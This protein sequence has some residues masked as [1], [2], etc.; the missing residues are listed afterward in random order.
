MLTAAAAVL[1]VLSFLAGGAMAVL[2]VVLAVVGVLAWQVAAASRPR[3]SHPRGEEPRPSHPCKEEPR[4]A[5]PGAEEEPPSPRPR[6]GAGASAGTGVGPGLIGHQRDRE[7]V[8]DEGGKR[9]GVEDLM[10]S[11]PHR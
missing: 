4:P 6:D 9:E 7:V 2:G 10:E 8:R 5:R 11:E 1:C 3:Q